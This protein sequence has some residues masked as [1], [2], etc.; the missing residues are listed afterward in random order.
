MLLSCHTKPTALQCDQAPDSMK[1]VSSTNGDLSGTNCWF[2]VRFNRSA[3][4][5]I[6]GPSQ[7]VIPHRA[8]RHKGQG[9]MT[10]V[11]ARLKHVPSGP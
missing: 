1:R 11:H 8:F 9:I 2:Q 3:V 10:P 5:M 7:S 6:S 4:T